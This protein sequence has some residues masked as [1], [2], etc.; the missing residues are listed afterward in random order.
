MSNNQGERMDEFV[1]AEVF[2]PGQYIRD[3]LSARGWTQTDLAEVMDRPV[4]TISQI[5]Q[6]KKRVTEETAKELEAALGIEAE[7]WLRI[8][9][10]YRLRHGEPAPSA[11][12]Q[13]AEIRRR[14]PLRLMVARGWITPTADVSEL[15]RHVED[16]LGAP[17]QERMPFAMAAMQ[18]AYDKE[19]SP[20]QEVWLLRAKKLA[21]TM[22][23]PPY[24][25]AKLSGCIQKFSALRMNAEDVRHVPKLLADAGVRFV[26]IERLPG[27][28]IDGVCF[29]LE[30]GTKPV[31][32]MSLRH[33][34]IDNF[35][36]VLRHECEHVLRGH[37][38]D[39]AIVDNDLDDPREV[40]E[41]ER[42]ANAAAA[43]FCVPTELMQSFMVRK[44]PLFTDMN[45]QQFASANGLHSG[46][47]A[48]QLRKRLSRGPLGEKAWKMFTSHL[49]RVRHFVVGTALVDGFGSPLQLDQ[50]RDS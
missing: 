33:D 12:A 40:T 10:A 46:L 28:G 16:Y 9:S 31:I 50:A 4:Q 48:G 5:V 24:S 20:E 8:E 44:G 27:L 21:E 11:I 14:V 37:G 49:E 19:L 36:F 30:N 3:E 15:R 23:V 45:I 41:Q 22:M 32:G 6:A 25:N 38:K 7:F 2:P 1:P 29:W 39:G 42:V 35:W 47:V 34:R 43:E 18:T 17:L 26:V 13:R